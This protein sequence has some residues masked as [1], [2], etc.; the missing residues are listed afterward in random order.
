MTP[1]P[2]HL[3]AVYRE[4]IACKPDEARVSLRAEQLCVALGSDLASRLAGMDLVLTEIDET[5]RAAKDALLDIESE[6]LARL[7][8]RKRLGYREQSKIESLSKR[9]QKLQVCR[10][11]SVHVG[12]LR[13]ALDT[14]AEE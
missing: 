5:C 11:V 7:Q 12:A 13:T 2:A 10:L 8:R 14:F 6:Q 9:R 3:R 1:D 4:A